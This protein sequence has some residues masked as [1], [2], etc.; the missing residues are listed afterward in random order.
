MDIINNEGSA[1]GT[2]DK[3]IIGAPKMQNNYGV[4]QL[5]NFQYCDNNIR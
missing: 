3:T 4:T 2:V 1:P 5:L